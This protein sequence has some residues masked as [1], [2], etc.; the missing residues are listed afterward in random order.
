[1]DLALAF[2]YGYL[3]MHVLLLEKNLVLKSLIFRLFFV[4][5]HHTILNVILL[6]HAICCIDSEEGSRYF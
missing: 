1:M 6:Y 5:F 3:V 4:F 2:E